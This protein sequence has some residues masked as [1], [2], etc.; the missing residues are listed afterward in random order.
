MH[1][2]EMKRHIK[3]TTEVT[4]ET[5]LC[6]KEATSLHAYLYMTEVTSF[7]AY[8]YMHILRK[9]PLESWIQMQT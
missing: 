9:E 8:L 3:V 4:E 2:F 6:M 1:M 5:Y 7:L